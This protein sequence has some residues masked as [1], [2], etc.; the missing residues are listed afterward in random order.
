MHTLIEEIDRIDQWGRLNPKE[1]AK[2]LAPQIGIDLPI[3][4]L[5]A[6]RLSYGV[7]PVSDEVLAQQQKIADTFLSLGLIPK[8]ISVA[9]AVRKVSA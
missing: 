8:P 5:A 9:D 3:V 7:K 4:E 6:Q 1:V 2:F